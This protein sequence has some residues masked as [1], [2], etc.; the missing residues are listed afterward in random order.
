MATLGAA[1]WKLAADAYAHRDPAGA[2]LLRRR[3]DEVDGLHVNLTAELAA[4]GATVPVA[5]EMALVARYLERLGDHAVNITRR[6]EQAT[7]HR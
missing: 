1:M 6:L 4:S 7:K 2:R 3:D 5:I